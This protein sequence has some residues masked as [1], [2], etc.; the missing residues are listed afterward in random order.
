M[1]SPPPNLQP[2]LLPTPEW[3]LKPEE[4]CFRLYRQNGIDQFP[5]NTTSF[6]TSCSKQPVKRLLV[7]FFR[8]EKK[9]KQS[10]HN[11]GVL[12]TKSGLFVLHFSS[13]AEKRQETSC[14]Y[15]IQNSFFLFF[16]SSNQQLPHTHLSGYSCCATW[17]TRVC[18]VSFPALR[19]SNSSSVTGFCRTGP[20]VVQVLAV[21][22]R[23]RIVPAGFGLLPGDWMLAG[24]ATPSWCTMN[25][26]CERV[27]LFGP[28]N[29]SW[30]T[31]L[32]AGH[33][34]VARLRFHTFTHG[35]TACVKVWISVFS[36]LLIFT[37][38]SSC[39]FWVHQLHQHAALS[40]FV[41]Y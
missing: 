37:Y 39:C 16:E 21:W 10:K 23:A 14:T 28:F 8:I 19:W 41:K 36:H 1:T 12:Q 27:L 7:A 29:H 4:K 30:I 6:R 24:L 32:P 35:R 25:W 20:E 17:Q 38:S 3:T 5:L 11:L 33:S 18:C 31:A 15:R 26:R 9:K 13:K 40:S 34:Q 22:G 2:G